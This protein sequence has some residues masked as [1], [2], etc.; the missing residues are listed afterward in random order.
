MLITILV[1]LH[2]VLLKSRA[3][4]SLYQDTTH[5]TLKKSMLIEKTLQVEGRPKDTVGFE[6]ACLGRSAYVETF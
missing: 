1:H 3:V 4:Y 6:A 2:S 5:M